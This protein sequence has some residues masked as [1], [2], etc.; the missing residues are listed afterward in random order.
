[1]KVSSLLLI[2]FVLIISFIHLRL[3]A[4]RQESPLL[5]LQEFQTEKL[6]L[7]KAYCSFCFFFAF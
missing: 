4:P 7:L 2:G 1:M 6:E 3:V 5:P